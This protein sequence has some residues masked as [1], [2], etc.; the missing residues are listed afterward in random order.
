VHDGRRTFPAARLIHPKRKTLMWCEPPALGTP[1][2]WRPDL[3]VVA[4]QP[5]DAAKWTWPPGRPVPA[6]IPTPESVSRETPA[7]SQKWWLTAEA[8]LYQ[9]PGSVDRRMAEGRMLRGLVTDGVRHL[10]RPRLARSR[11]PEPPLIEM[12]GDSDEDWTWLPP[13]EP[14]QADHGDV[15]TV[16]SWFAALNPPHMRPRDWSSRRGLARYTPLQ[17][18]LLFVAADPK[19]N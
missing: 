15:D 14:T 3:E 19:P 6:P 11:L 12:V 17:V 2:R 1:M 5:L 8:V 9:K 18:V 16:M 4:W 7:S 13:L 10:A